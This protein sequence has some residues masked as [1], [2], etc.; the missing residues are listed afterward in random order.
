VSGWAACRLL[1]RAVQTRG[2]VSGRAS[3]RLLTRAV[4]TRGAVGWCGGP[5]LAL[6]LL[7]VGASSLVEGAYTGAYPSPYFAYDYTWTPG[8]S[9]TPWK[10]N[11]GASFGSSSVTFGSGGSIIYTATVSGTNSNDYEVESQFSPASGA[12]YVHSAGQ[13]DDRSGRKREL[14]IAW[15]TNLRVFLDGQLVWGT[16]I[17][18]TGGNP[19]VGAYGSTPGAFTQV[20][21]GRPDTVDPNPINTE[22]VTSSI[23]PTSVSLAWPATTD[24]SA[25]IA[26]LRKALDRFSGCILLPDLL[27]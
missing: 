1:T 3:C 20:A 6:L 22:P 2:T 19:G 12:N 18:Q 24:D 13:P 27:E 9:T 16:E 11:G 23:F 4:Q 17:P 5:T 10:A 21:I 15:E 8:A 7:A 26:L 25:G 14:R